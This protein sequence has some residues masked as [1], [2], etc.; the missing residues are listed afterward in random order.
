MLGFDRLAGDMLPLDEP[1]P[2]KS[3]EVRARRT[4]AAAK[5]ARRARKGE[6]RNRGQAEGRKGDRR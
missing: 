2:A 5:S 6:R 4:A 3:P 1:D